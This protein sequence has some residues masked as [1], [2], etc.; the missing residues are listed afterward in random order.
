MARA[1][2]SSYAD[3]FSCCAHCW[4]NAE[5]ALTDSAES[6]QNTDEA[7]LSTDGSSSS[8]GLSAS[9][10][11]LEGVERQHR[12]DKQDSKFVRRQGVRSAR[13]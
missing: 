12:M 10:D 9:D 8:E 11:A 13:M 4:Q 2:C 3:S 1:T 5:A 7:L 6:E